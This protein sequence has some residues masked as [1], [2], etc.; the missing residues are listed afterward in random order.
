MSNTVLKSLSDGWMSRIFIRHWEIPY[1]NLPEDESAVSD[2]AIVQYM[3]GYD[4]GWDE[5]LRYCGR[6]LASA[7]KILEDEDE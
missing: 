5:A 3:K 1:E 2:K 7:L 4:K 6:T